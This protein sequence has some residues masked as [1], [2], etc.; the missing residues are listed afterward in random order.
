MSESED[1][2]LTSISKAR[3]LKEIAEFWDT[4]STADYWDQT[5]EVEF[6]I[7]APR[8]RHVTVDPEIYE[9]IEKQARVRGL[10]PETLINLWLVERLQAAHSA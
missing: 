3:T 7:R 2:Q 5:Y 9:Q 4:H 6:E 8:R 10:L 1:T